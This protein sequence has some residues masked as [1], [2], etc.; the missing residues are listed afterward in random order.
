MHPYDPA[1]HALTI[2]MFSHSRD[3]YTPAPFI[4]N[5]VRIL[6][7]ILK[8]FC[9]AVKTPIYEIHGTAFY[10]TINSDGC[11]PELIN[12]VQK[13][14]PRSIQSEM[15][16]EGL[17]SYACNVDVETSKCVEDE[18]TYSIYLFIYFVHLN[19]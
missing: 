14:L 19:S 4:L 15:C 18:V 6:L 8:Y 3:Y 7:Y 9:I 11:T 10:K 12:N 2:Q 1:Q 16:P 5:S 13:Q 17:S